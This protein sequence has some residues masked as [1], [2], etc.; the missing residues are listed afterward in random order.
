MTNTS[1]SPSQEA[2]SIYIN[3]AI[4]AR[5]RS[6]LVAALLGM[7]LGGIGAHRF[8]L[9]YRRTA[10]LQLALTICTLGAAA[11]WGVAEGWLI[12]LGR[13]ARDAHGAGLAHRTG[14]QLLAASVGSLTVN[15][16]TVLGAVWL[17]HHYGPTLV[18]PPSGVNSVAIAMSMPSTSA[19][20]PKPQEI[21]VSLEPPELEVEEIE[22]LAE[23]N[24]TD[25][26]AKELLEPARS[27]SSRGLPEAE[28]VAGPGPT[29]QVP[30]EAENTPPNRT[31]S[32]AEAARL[33]PK[34]IAANPPQVAKA[35]MP[36]TPAASEATQARRASAASMASQENRGF[37]TD[38]LPSK[39]EFPQPVYPPELRRR[40]ITGLVKLRVRVGVDGKVKAASIYRT[41]GHRQFD[42][43]ALAVIRRWRFEPAR[44]AG[45]PVEMEIA[46]PIR[47]VIEEQNNERRRNR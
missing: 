2:T 20:P 14:A 33:P 23:L 45:V 42:Q 43:A 40:G 44:Q 1:P 11:L 5:R 10:T 8:Y 15:A 27:E 17:A 24:T 39:V 7:F 32:R 3:T 34:T 16:A 29:S 18:P 9:G 38:A 30:R 26:T 13:F 37:D 35:E 22:R 4:A 41:S 46:V 6:R 25:V 21:E 36:V 31:E 47:F 28:A 19:A 12:L